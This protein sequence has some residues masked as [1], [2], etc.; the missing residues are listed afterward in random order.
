MIKRV[1]LSFAISLLVLTVFASAITVDVVDKG[2]VIIKELGNPAVF[3][4]KVSAGLAD[5]YEIYSFLGVSFSPRGTFDLPK[6][7]STTEVKVYPNS[8]ILD[9]AGFYNFEYQLNGQSSGIYKGNLQ[10]KLVTMSQT[11][12]LTAEPLEVTDSTA[13]V[14]ITNTQNTNLDNVKIELHSPLFEYSEVISLHPYESTT[15]N[16]V[17]DRNKQRTLKAGQ[18]IISGDVSLQGAKGEIEGTIEYLE[19]ENIQTSSESDGFLVRDT[20]ITKSNEGNI[21]STAVTVAKRDAL[22]RLF[23][24]FSKEPLSSERNGFIVTYSW[25][26]SLKPGESN[27]VTVSTNYTLPFIVLVLIIVVV[28]LVRKTTNASISV[29]KSVSFVRTKGGEFALKVT[30]TA[31]SDKN[32]ENIQLIDSVPAVM[33][34]YHK[35]GH[36][37][38][39]VD[40]HT[41]RLFWD[42]DRL[43][44]GE[45]RVFS[46]IIYSNIKVVG[47]FELPAAVA[48]FE[49]NGQTHEV[50]SN[51]AFFSTS[52]VRGE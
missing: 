13:K 26:A 47:R 28:V 36:A 46:Y 45:S 16:V 33:K 9:L 19:S 12:E 24:T 30:L 39:R 40:A 38:D 11:L 42:I 48:V 6:G 22:S 17:T 50:Y 8:E 51:R 2:S 52:A 34:L 35:Y 15:L 18:Y 49:Q 3:D 5:T 27:V 21:Q 37:P 1:I 25:E 23:T 41:R 14:K 29:A 31:T 4:F 7:M 10:I 43:S 44:A 32:V 20:T